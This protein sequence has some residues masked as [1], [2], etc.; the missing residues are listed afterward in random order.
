MSLRRAAFRFHRVMSYFVFAQV[1][2]WVSG[3]VVCALSGAVLT[4]SAA[5]RAWRGRARAE[6]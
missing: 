6:G 3:G 2:A 1:L 4:A 5:R